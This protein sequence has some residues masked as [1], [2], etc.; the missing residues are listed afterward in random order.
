MS[1]AEIRV[2]TPA[3]SWPTPDKAIQ[4]ETI[5]ISKMDILMD[6]GEIL[7]RVVNVG[8]IPIRDGKMNGVL[9]Y[10]GYRHNQ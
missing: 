9:K 3:Q 10:V 8:M 1:E 5:S 2:L 7:V 6:I 4:N